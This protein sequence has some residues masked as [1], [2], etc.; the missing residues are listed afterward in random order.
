MLIMPVSQSRADWPNIAGAQYA[1]MRWHGAMPA[2]PTNWVWTLFKTARLPACVSKMANVWAWTQIA[3]L[4]A[5]PRLHPALQDRHRVLCR[6]P[7]CAC[8]L[9]RMYFRPLCPRD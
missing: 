1:M 8:Q 2:L 9:N 5:Q 7:A 3:D 6:W 4:L